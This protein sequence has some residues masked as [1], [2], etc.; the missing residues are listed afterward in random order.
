MRDLF[1]GILSVSLSSSLMILL[2]IITR[3]VFQKAPKSLVCCLWLIVVLRMLIPFQLETTW[4]LHPKLPVITAQ[5][6]QMHIDAKPVVD[7]E[8]AALIPQQTIE[9][10]Y[11]VVVDYLKIAM[12]VWSIGALLIG[13]YTVVSYFRLKFWVREAVL[14]ENGVYVSANVETAFLLGYFRPCIYLPSA[15]D[16]KEAQIVIAHERAH[17]KRGDNWLKLLGF[18]ALAIHWFNPLM[19][20]AY[21]MLC[22][23]IEDACDAKVVQDMDPEGRK[24]YSEA[25]LACGKKSRNV[26]G[27]PV[28]FGEISIRKR[29]LNILGYKKPA[30]WISV[31]LIVIIVF[32]SVFF[33]TDPVRQVDPPQYKTLR[34]QLGQPMNV[35]CKNL[36]LS[37]KDLVSLGEGTGLYDTPLKVEYEGVTMNVRLGF[38]VSND[39][40]H[41]FTYCAVYEGGHEGAAKDIVTLSNRLWENF[42][43][44]YQWYEREDPKRLKESTINDIL[45]LYSERNVYNLAYDQWNLTHQAS[46]SVR[47]WLDQIEVSHI[48][49][50][51]WA[52]KAQQFG[53]SP[54]YYMEYRAVYEEESDLTIISITYQAGWQPGHY[55][56]MVSSS[57]N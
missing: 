3:V 45:N 14:K 48:W 37:E 6:T 56:S 12:I 15:I 44:G 25:L 30:G 50:K 8:I 11:M 47:T 16:D 29:I 33:A 51:N 55:G 5:D 36:G 24:V 10:T 23:D 57:Y 2:V 27:C 7:G 54:H 13:A 43:K 18:I 41:S 38:G 17:I 4:A 49:Q 34:D 32:I 31:F 42:G 20:V 22:R 39:L 53:L 26:F 52:E 35:V 1:A 19:W 21:A 28:A 46:K 40:L 9:G